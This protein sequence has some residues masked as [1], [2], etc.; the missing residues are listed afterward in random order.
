MK[1][2]EKKIIQPKEQATQFKEEHLTKQE[3]IVI[4]GIHSKKYIENLKKNNINRDV[5]FI[6]QGK[7]V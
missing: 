4:E 3:R 1:T 6:Y 7:E 5:V 2:L